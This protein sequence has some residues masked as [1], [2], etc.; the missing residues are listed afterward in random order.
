M[1]IRQ[2]SAARNGEPL[3]TGS[4]AWV[5]VGTQRSPAPRFVGESLP[6]TFVILADSL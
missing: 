4:R 1:P 3:E 2:K 6:T 5:Y